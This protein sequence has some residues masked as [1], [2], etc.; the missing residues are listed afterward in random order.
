MY[1]VIE[2]RI[3]LDGGI[4]FPDEFP[5]REVFF[6]TLMLHGSTPGIYIRCV[7]GGMEL[8]SEN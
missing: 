5:S 7:C 8:G 6:D 4:F 3:I 1:I 2:L